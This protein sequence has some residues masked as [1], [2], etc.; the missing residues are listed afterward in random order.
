MGSED[1][2]LTERNQLM[3]RIAA[4]IVAL[5][6]L[7][8]I[9]FAARFV[10]R[11]RAL[12]DQYERLK[13]G[14]SKQDVLESFGQPNEVKGCNPNPNCKDYFMYISFMERWGVVFDNEDRVVDKFY[15][16]GSF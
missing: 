7:I 2:S 1:G 15:N 9:G 12:A 4:C 8:P 5:I 16:A 13:R 10:Y 6:I 11:E 14:T 3:K